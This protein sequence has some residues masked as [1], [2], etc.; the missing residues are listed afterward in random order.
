MF[1]V[2]ANTRTFKFFQCT[3][4][5]LPCWLW[6]FAT[7]FSATI[8]CCHTGDSGCD[9][10]QGV[11]EG[12]YSIMFKLCLLLSSS[13][14]HKA[15]AFTS[16]LSVLQWQSCF[17]LLLLPPRAAAFPMYFLGTQSPV[18]YI[19]VAHL[20]EAG[21]MKR[22]QKNEK[23]FPPFCWDE[24]SE[25]CS[26]KVLSPEGNAYVMGRSKSIS[27]NVVFCLFVFFPTAPCERS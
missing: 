3:C 7:Y 1:A 9:V 6:G 8:L 27:R 15:A 24:I 20:H 5:C 21:S 12:D 22:I 10:R 14:C 23:I 18:D 16:V 17:T 26:G 13:L 11:K 2:T 25:L 19:F 4:F